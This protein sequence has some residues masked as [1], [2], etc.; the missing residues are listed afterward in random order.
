MRQVG[1]IQRVKNRGPH[2][3]TRLGVRARTGQALLFYVRY[4][5]MLDIYIFIVF[6]V[7][8]IFIFIYKY[9]TTVFNSNMFFVYY[10]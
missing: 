9:R 5:D 10:C 8:L 2:I 4:V 6:I 7:I 1:R 3:A